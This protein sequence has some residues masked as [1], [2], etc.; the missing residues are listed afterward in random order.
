MTHDT[1]KKQESWLRKL[2]RSTPPQVKEDTWISILSLRK[3]A[4]TKEHEDILKLIE[5]ETILK[6]YPEFGLFWTTYEI[7]ENTLTEYHRSGYTPTFTIEFEGEDK[8]T[9]SNTDNDEIFYFIKYM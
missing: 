9:F 3:L 6:S 4:R 1:K 5:N 7:H 2:F 8:L